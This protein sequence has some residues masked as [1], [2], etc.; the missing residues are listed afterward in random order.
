MSRFVILF[1]VVLATPG[2]VSHIA[3]Y[4]AKQRDFEVGQY[5]NDDKPARNS[6]FAQGRRGLFEDERAG[7]IGDM[8]VITIDEADSATHDDSTK[9]SKAGN[10]SIGLTGGLVDLLQKA[11]P[12]VQLASLLG[13]NSTSGFNGAGTISKSGKLT[14]SLPVRVRK[15]M[16]NG[17]LYV[18]GTKVVMVGSEEHH[19]YVSGIVRQMDLQ[20]D[21]SVS[22]SRVADAEIEYTGRGDISDHT[23]PGWLHRIINKVNPL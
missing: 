5:A 18:E 1:T 13:T 2:C 17:D 23:R 11:I 20:T 4:T 15:V 6:L 7:R 10:L 3:P 9:L 8:V 14:G 12:A 21:G 16:P 22:S 19:L